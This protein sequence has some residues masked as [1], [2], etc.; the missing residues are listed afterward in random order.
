MRT[1]VTVLPARHLL[2]HDGPVSVL[3]N[4][5]DLLI[6]AGE[7]VA[8]QVLAFESVVVGE[9]LV[10][11]VLDRFEGVGSLALDG[12]RDVCGK[13]G[14]RRGAFSSPTYLTTMPARQVLER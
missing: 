7:V 11:V 8:L 2:D 6:V 9:Q 1:D 12:I 5:H 4:V 3:L 13:I 10:D 14:W